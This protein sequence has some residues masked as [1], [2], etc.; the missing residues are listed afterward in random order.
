MS[1]TEKL[2]FVALAYPIFKDLATIVYRFYLERRSIRN[3]KGGKKQKR[4]SHKR[5]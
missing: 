3:K 5:R 1:A 4:R 2:Q